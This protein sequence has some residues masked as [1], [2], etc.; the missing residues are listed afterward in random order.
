MKLHLEP[1]HGTYQIRRYDPQSVTINET[2]YTHS[3]IIMPEYLS[4]WAVDRFETL[5]TTHFEPLRRLH[6]EIVLLGTGPHLRFP[7]SALLAPLINDGIGVEV[8]DT[9]AACRTYSILMSD[10]R[11]VAAA[12]II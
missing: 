6:P 1:S 2:V 5:E 11:A 10:R 8:M 4:A 12:L 3:L 9:P 7:P